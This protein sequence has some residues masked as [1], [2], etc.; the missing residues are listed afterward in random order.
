MAS[1]FVS[2]FEL[3][4]KRIRS[5]VAV[6]IQEDTLFGSLKEAKQDKLPSTSLEYLSN[7]EHHR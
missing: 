2:L 1:E 7:D 5:S 4:S 6:E 3:E